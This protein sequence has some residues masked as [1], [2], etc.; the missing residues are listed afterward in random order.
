MINSKLIQF[1]RVFTKPEL[2]RFKDFVHSP[3]FNK[4]Q[5]TTELLDYILEAK[6]WDSTSLAKEKAF[7]RL[8]PG[9]K[10]KEQHLRTVMSYLVQLIYQFYTSQH[11][12]T[13]ISEQ[14]IRLLEMTLPHG[15]KK[16]FEQASASWQKKVMEL[17]LRDSNYF[18]QQ[19]R[20]HRLLDTFDLKY[21][22]RVSGGFLE[23]AIANFDNYYLGEKLRMTCEML[24]RKQ[25]TGQKY[26]FFLL[27]D[28]IP[29]L[30][31]EKA[32]FQPI[33]GV[34]IYYLI[35]QMMIEDQPEY[36]Y[37]LKDRLEQDSLLFRPEEG[38]DLYTHALNYCIGRLN[39]GEEIFRKEAFELYQQMLTNGLIYVDEVM[40]R[41][42]YTNIVSLGCEL[43]ESKWIARFITEQKERLPLAEREN[44]STYCLASFHYYQKNY[45]AAISLLQKVE[46]TE[47][48]YSLLTRLLMLKIY[49]ETQDWKTLEY[50]LET[51]RIYLLRNKQLGESRR[52]S[53]LNLI[54]Y[55]R[56][57]S[58]LLAAKSSISKREFKEK[59]SA[60]Q[61]KIKDDEKVLNKSWL[62]SKWEE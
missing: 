8:F 45:D 46:F 27:D 41:W 26:S 55:T 3:F 62:L 34:W 58:R 32:H 53:G 16:M 29:F 30:E 57:L 35:Y 20:Y 14:Q 13:E 39:F 19:A 15:Q 40:P 2:R 60:L 47:V 54:K 56:N 10:Y 1:L 51:F 42:D 50:F 18:L 44:T 22:K 4:H 33:S 59:R 49:F 28:L 11:K 36:F 6:S 9:K 31:K 21:G 52:K 24:A 37:Q 48:Y 7:K 43:Q 61:L 23:K 12:A 17:P 5:K 25:V 38:R